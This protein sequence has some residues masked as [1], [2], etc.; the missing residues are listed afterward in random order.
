MSRR[1]KS[2]TTTVITL[3]RNEPDA[4]HSDVKFV[5]GVNVEGSAAATSVLGT[6]VIEGVWVW[7]L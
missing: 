5:Y 3:T 1:V 7:A 2:K 4:I 6:L